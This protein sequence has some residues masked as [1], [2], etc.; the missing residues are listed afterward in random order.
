[1]DFFGGVEL[2]PISFTCLAAASSI[3]AGLAAHLLRGPAIRIG[4]FS[5]SRKDRFGHGRIPLTGGVGLLAGIAVALLALR[6]SP[7]PAWLVGG[8]GFFLLGLLDDRFEFRPPAKF[9]AQVLVAL[10]TVWI[11]GPSWR[12]AG[13]ILFLL[14]LLVNASNFLDNM[15]GLLAGVALVE[16]VALLEFSL[17]AGPGAAVLVW[18]LPGILL[19]TIPPARVYLGD[20]GSHLIGALLGLEAARL[21]VQPDGVHIRY[22]L[23]LA[24]LFGVQLLDLTTVV[25]SRIRRH[26]PILRGGLDHL[27]HR[28]VRLGFPVAKAVFLLVL[29]SGVCGLAALLL[30]LRS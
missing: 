11:L 1:M 29:A 7:P 14:L 20:S 25:V 26:R 3:A 9:S 24:L 23:P 5:R 17:V 28:L 19:L 6:V 18:A 8:G 15:D 22:I 27:S 2:S 16:A 21:L 4:F 12:Y 10:L 30:L 13:F